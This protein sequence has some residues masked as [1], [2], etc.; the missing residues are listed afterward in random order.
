[1]R[2]HNRILD[3]IGTHVRNHLDP[4]WEVSLDLSPQHRLPPYIFGSGTYSRLRPDIIL[5]RSHPRTLILAEL[6]CPLPC[7][8]TRSHGHKL[9]K[10]SPL[11]D[12]ARDEGWESHLHVILA[13][14]M[15]P[16][17]HGLPE[18]LDR[19]GVPHRS[20]VE[21]CRLLVSHLNSQIVHS[22]ELV[23]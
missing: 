21:E 5:T 8:I 2:R 16:S 4:Q 20:T 23:P 6:A 7:N 1:M 11:I 12:M 3:S 15:P 10:Y 17:I 22:Q 13:C 9:T 19:I 18:F 14:G